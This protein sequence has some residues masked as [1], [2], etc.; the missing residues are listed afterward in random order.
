[1]N[2]EQHLTA[3]TQPWDALVCPSM[4]VRATVEHIIEQHADDLERR[5]GRRGLLYLS[6]SGKQIVDY[7]PC[8]EA[9]ERRD[10][11]AG[12]MPGGAA[13]AVF[14]PGHHLPADS[15]EP[16]RYARMPGLRH[17][18]FATSKCMPSG[19]PLK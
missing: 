1:M 15:H 7:D 12:C 19:R 3:P 6:E 18:S 17:S 13:V 5:G 16:S 4:A 9:S 8:V 11:V 14:P 2:R 10:A